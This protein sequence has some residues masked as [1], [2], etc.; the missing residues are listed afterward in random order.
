[1]ADEVK[2]AKKKATRRKKTAAPRGL[3]ASEVVGG[4]VEAIDEL[5]AG[6]VADG[7]AVVGSYRE[8]LGGMWQLVAALPIEKVSATPYQRDLSPA[9]VTRLSNA[10][11]KLGRFMDPIVAVRTPDGLYWT[12]NGHHR[13]AAMRAL[14]AKSIMALVVP[15]AEVAHRILVLNTE[16][17]HNVRERALEVIRLAEDLAQLDDGLESSYETEFEEPSLLT[18]GCC[19][20]VNGRFSGGAY[21]PVLKRVESFMALKLSRALEVRRERAAQLLE[22]DAAVAEAVAELKKRGFESPYLKAFV[23]A[24]INPLRWDKSEKKPPFDATIAKMMAAVEKFDVNKVRADQVARSGGP[25]E[26]SQN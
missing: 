5:A 13:L 26:D 20:Q 7:G 6:V 12:P 1:M 14:G 2:P 24:R 19:Y 15:E 21:Q 17:A 23:L 16:K 10:I 11:D 22:L 9:H 8:P 4:S 3:A 18:L 25:P